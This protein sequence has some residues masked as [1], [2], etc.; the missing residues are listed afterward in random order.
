[1]NWLTSAAPSQNLS[2]GTQIFRLW[3]LH[4]LVSGDLRGHKI[5]KFFLNYNIYYDQGQS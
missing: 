4:S 5:Q 3:G 2:R 1:M